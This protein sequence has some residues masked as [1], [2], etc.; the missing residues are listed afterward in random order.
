MTADT[1][2][3]LYISAD[4]SDLTTR[5]KATPRMHPR[6]DAW[7]PKETL[8]RL[9]EAAVNLMRVFPDPCRHDHHGYCQEHFIEAECSVL[10]LKN[11]LAA[12]AEVQADARRE[13]G[14]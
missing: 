7:V 9:R 1:P 5:Y 8:E 4:T 3:V 13:G 6:A 14:E 10:A 2:P 11:A 12:L